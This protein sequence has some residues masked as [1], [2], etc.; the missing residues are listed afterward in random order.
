MP[1]LAN[2]FAALCKVPVLRKFLWKRWYQYLAGTKTR[3]PW[4][5]MN[6]GYESIGNPLAIGL[7]GQDEPDRYSIQLYHELVGS[8]ELAGKD[9]LEVGSGR[10]GGASYLQR[11]FKARQ[12]V[13]LDFSSKAVAFCSAYHQ[14]PGLLFRQG[15]AEDLPFPDASLDVVIN[16]E[17]SHCY[18]NL[19]AFFSEVRRV[20]RPGGSFLHTDFRGN[21][22]I[23]S[24]R[25]LLETSGM[26]MIQSR[27]ITG[28]VLA[29]LD[30]DN[31]RKMKLIEETVPKLLVKS[32][33][34]FA[35]MKG[36]TVYEYFR[37]REMQYFLF[38]LKK[39][40]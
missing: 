2:S 29:A 38:V 39:T 20:L 17:S 28:N 11:Y 5:F 13:G 30:A 10:G 22:K 25:K 14:V 34:D 32:F 35:G 6:Y 18:G 36:S 3:K 12:M 23:E 24:W 16:V 19:E 33:L 21:D 31:D 40:S 4:T 8:V 9:V 26:K 37:T 7:E 15:D 27:E 1:L